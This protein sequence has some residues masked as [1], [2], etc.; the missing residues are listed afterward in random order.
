M[1]KVSDNTVLD[2]KKII[3]IQKD[4]DTEIIFYF[5]NTVSVVKYNSEA[6]R[7]QYYARLCKFFNTK[8][9]EM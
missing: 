4:K 7:N 5:D 8:T 1:I 6:Q 9:I 3:G 2:E